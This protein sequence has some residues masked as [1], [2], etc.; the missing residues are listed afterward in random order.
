MNVLDR[1]MYSEAEAARLL[2]VARGTLHYWLEGGTRR[3]KTYKPVVRI[4]P[5]GARSVTWAE[6]LEAALL[7]EYHH[8]QPTPILLRSVDR[9]GQLPVVA[10]GR[11]TGSVVVP[12]ESS[13]GTLAPST[14]RVPMAELRRFIDLLRD[15]YG[16]PYPLA[17]YE[18]FISGRQLVYEAQAGSDP[19][20]RIAG[21]HAS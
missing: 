10:A 13:G 1:E 12:R 8:H 16:V 5:T 19:N 3:G 21:R 9:P 2:R 20:P 11:Q 7:R 17:H 14:H 18:P 15:H 6:F 4:E